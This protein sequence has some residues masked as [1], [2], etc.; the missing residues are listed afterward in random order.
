MTTTTSPDSGTGAV[1]SSAAAPALCPL[2]EHP[3]NLHQYIFALESRIAALETALRENHERTKAMGTMIFSNPAT[4]MML[5]AFPK[6]AQT[7]L[8]EMFGGSNAVTEKSN[9]NGNS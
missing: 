6:E 4:K 3:E 1:D 7:K 5:A 2:C 8:K 9:V